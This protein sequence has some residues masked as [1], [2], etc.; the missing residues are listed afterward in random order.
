[1]EIAAGIRRIGDG[2]V[3]VYLVEEAGRITI[4]DAGAPGYWRDLPAEVAA[5]GRSLDDVHALLLTHAHADHI[6]FAERIRRE[7]GVPV[8]VH[9]DDAALARGEIGQVRDPHGP[10]YRGL[11]LR[12]VAGFAVFG[13]SHGMTKVTR[14][15]EVT[16]FLDGATLDVP[17]APRVVH[18][19]GHTAGSVV[20][21]LADRDAVF[22]G[23]AFATRNVVTG[24]RG[25]HFA[26]QFNADKPAGHR[27]PRAP[28]RALRPARAAG[29]RGGLAGGA[30]GGGPP[31][32]GQRPRR[33]ARLN[34]G[35]G[36]S[37]RSRDG[38]RSPAAAAVSRT[39][40]PGATCRRHGRGRRGRASGRRRP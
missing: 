33:A 34:D 32:P 2:L 8:R 31:R 26:A 3:N 28:G 18:V 37:P 9:A 25:P 24:R 6:G 27:V 22:V 40:A 7:R 1:M 39:G 5:M 11:S 4:I 12:A 30:R 38:P 23:D 17:G 20:F 10:G 13:L 29:P 35:P 15:A 36:T 21:H 16:T 14:I 19:P